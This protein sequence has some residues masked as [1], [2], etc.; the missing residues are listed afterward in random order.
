MVIAAFI[1]ALLN[2]LQLEE[3]NFIENP[4]IPSNIITIVHFRTLLT[5]CLGGLLPTHMSHSD[6]Y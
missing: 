5:T 3:I 4:S 1:H 2:D 6:S